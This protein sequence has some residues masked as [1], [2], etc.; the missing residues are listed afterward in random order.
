MLPRGAGRRA[1]AGEMVEWWGIHWFCN[2]PPWHQQGF[3]LS[4][5]KWL[6]WGFSRGSFRVLQV[7]WSSRS[8]GLGAYHGSCLLHLL[9]I[10][11]S[12]R[13]SPWFLHLCRKQI[14]TTEEL[15]TLNHYKA[16]GSYPCPPCFRWCGKTKRAEKT[17]LSECRGCLTGSDPTCRLAQPSAVL[18]KQIYIKLL[19]ENKGEYERELSGHEECTEWCWWRQH[20]RV[21]Q[22]GWKVLE[23]GKL[24]GGKQPGF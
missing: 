20:L 23:N 2:P 4:G 22:G 8:R 7:L 9:G 1:K 18:I 15:N 19:C 13:S 5:Q 16:K 12:G 11:C 3:C 6:L 17:L 24:L 10:E 14:P 21:G